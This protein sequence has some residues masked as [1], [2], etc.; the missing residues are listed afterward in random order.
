MPVLAPISLAYFLDPFEISVVDKKVAALKGVLGEIFVELV[1]LLDAKILKKC[2]GREYGA[3]LTDSPEH[4]F[5][6]G[7]DLALTLIGRN[8]GLVNC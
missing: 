2:F 3:N 4:I 8:S 1:V 6:N 5:I 7:L